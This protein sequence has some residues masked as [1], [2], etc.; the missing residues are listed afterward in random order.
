MLR[1]STL[2]LYHCILN[3][4]PSKSGHCLYWY[5]GTLPLVVAQSGFILFRAHYD[6]PGVSVQSPLNKNTAAFMNT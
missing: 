2:G 1:R 3:I 5:T 6:G 4:L